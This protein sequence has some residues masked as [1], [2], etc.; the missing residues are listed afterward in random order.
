MMASLRESL[1][2]PGYVILNAIRVLN[3]ITFLDLIAAGVV[4]LVKINMLNSYFFFEAVT[5]AVV[6]LISSK[7]NSFCSNNTVLTYIYQSS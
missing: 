4:M 7:Y 6:V 1:A 5:H 3:I 2:G